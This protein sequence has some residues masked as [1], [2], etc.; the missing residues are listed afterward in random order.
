M[1][2]GSEIL[3][4][5]APRSVGQA[6]A[7]KAPGQSPK[8]WGNAPGFVKSD[9]TSAES[10]TQLSTPVERKRYVDWRLQR[11]CLSNRALGRCPRLWV[12]QRLWR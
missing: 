10:A 1:R 4:V 7:P 9:N 8:A 12:R 6:L 3:Q 11:I 2:N 5:S